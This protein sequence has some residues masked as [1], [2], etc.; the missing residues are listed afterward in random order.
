MADKEI[1]VIGAGLGGLSAA[2]RLASQGCKV[3]VYEQNDQP[4]G[5][6]NQ[7]LLDGFRFDTGPSLLTMPFVL[8][9]LFEYSGERIED[10]LEIIPLNVLCKYFYSDGTVINAYS[11]MEKFSSE[12][13][14]KTS[15]SSAT[16][17]KYLKY[18][19]TI[20]DYTADLFL[21]GSFSGIKNFINLKSFKTLFNIYK[22]DPFRTMHDANQ[23][24][25]KDNKTIQLFDRYATYNGS[26]PFQ[27]PATLN[28]IQHVEYNLGG[29]IV[30][31]GI[32]SIVQALYKLCEKKGV[33]FF[34]NSKVESIELKGC[35]VRG[36]LVKRNGESENKKYSVV[37]SN[38]DVNYTYQNILKDNLSMAAVR[39]KNQTPSSSALVFY[40]GVEGNYEELEIHNILFSIN[41][42]EEF[43]DLFLRKIYPEDPTVYIYISSKYREDDALKGHENWFVMINVPYLDGEENKKE[44]EKAKKTILRKIK[45]ILKIDL[46]NKIK[47][48]KVLSPS[49]IEKQTGSFKGSIYGVSSNNKSAAFLRQ[50]N[51]SKEYKGLFFCGGSAHPGGGIPLVLLSGKIVSEEI[52]RYE[53]E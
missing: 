31:D 7:I 32:Y 42:K 11:D 9:E 25:F 24:F 5:K 23:S 52:M 19:K 44:I 35:R 27:A 49:I 4:G 40:W 45:E 18:S 3:D 1:A 36:I 28:I 8:K 37:L 38:A 6:A 41:Y 12:I 26:N 30:K 46:S 22:I 34:F 51:R 48:E 21:Y 2:L 16:V 43:D 47:F 10:Y 39:Y 13:E 50:K 29:F 33:R 14:N 17:K 53:Q 20:Y 15:D